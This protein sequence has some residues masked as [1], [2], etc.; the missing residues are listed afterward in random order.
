MVSLGD[1]ILGLAPDNWTSD[2]FGPGE[3]DVAQP[4]A[5]G[6]QVWKTHEDTGA[7]LRCLFRPLRVDDR[8]MI[9]W[10]GQHPVV[11]GRIGTDFG[12]ED[13]GDPM[14]GGEAGPPGPQGPVGPTGP[15]GATGPA[16]P[17]G[18]DG[19]QGPVGA[20]GPQGPIG[21]TGPVGPTG[22]QG[23]TGNTGPQGPQGTVGPIGPAGPQGDK[24]DTGAT[25]ATGP[26]GPK[27][28]T[29]AQGPI[30]LT[31]PQ[32][33]IGNTGP[34]GPV[35]PA[36]SIGSLPDGTVTAPG[37]AFAADTNTG[38]YRPANDTFGIAAGGQAALTLTPTQATFSGG[39]SG[40]SAVTNFQLT[41]PSSNLQLMAGGTNNVEL[42]TNGVRRWYVDGAT[43]GWFAGA[44][45]AY[46]IGA[47]GANR[48]RDLFVGR[49]QV[50]GGTT[51]HVGNVS[52]G[53]TPVTYSGLIFQP[54]LSGANQFAFYAPLTFSTSGTGNN[55]AVYVLPTF[56]AG[57]RTVTSGASFYADAPTLGAGVTVT[58]MFGLYVA[59]Q[60]KTGVTNAYGIYIAAQAG[61]TTTNFGIRNDGT[62]RLS[63]RVGINNDPWVDNTRYV[64]ISGVVSIFN[65]TMSL[66]NGMGVGPNAATM[67]NVGGNLTGAATQNGMY[68]RVNGDATATAQLC[69]IAFQIGTQNGSYTIPN[70]TGIYV[71][72]PIV[73]TGTTITNARGIN[74]VNQGGAGRVNAYGMYLQATSGASG[75][76]VSLYN[77]GT[78]QFMDRIGVMQGPN[79]AVLVSLR[80]QGTAGT[81][82]GFQYLKSDASNNL[83]YTRDDGMMF[84]TGPV[85]VGT[86]N[87]R[88][89]N[90]P[91]S[92]SNLSIESWDGYVM[93]SSLSG[94]HMGGNAYWDGT[95]WQRFS[96]AAAA[97]AWIINAGAASFYTVAAGANPISWTAPFS[98]SNTGGVTADAFA[99]NGKPLTSGQI[100]GNYFVSDGG[101]DL[102]NG[103]LY[104]AHN[105]GV[106]WSWNGTYL[107]STHSIAN[108]GTSYFFVNNSSVYVQ[109]TG[110]L[111]FSHPIEIARGSV[112]GGAVITA[113]AARG[114]NAPMTSAGQG[115]FILG[116]GNSTLYMH[117]NLSVAIR[118]DYPTCTF[119][120]YGSITVNGVVTPSSQRY[121]SDIVTIPHALQL[122]MD[123]NIEGVHYTY[124]PPELADFYTQPD[125]KYGF[126]AEPWYDKA[127]DVVTLDTGGEPHALDYQQITAILF[128]AF[129]EYVVQTDERIRQLE[130]GV[131]A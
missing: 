13:V 81:T 96:T 16:G 3:F 84:T 26:Q 74:V 71:D 114:Y 8:V 115:D 65:G 76:N 62:T 63:G 106:N 104:F 18:P 116:G 69:G 58:S 27:G 72:G 21:N 103:P 57:T 105:G 83:F 43:G 25:G 6:L 113:Q 54:T 24:G 107:V 47:S 97:A 41:A 67:L 85:W 60:G 56:A 90:P 82:Y 36:G 100:Y 68:F 4:F 14:G 89:R 55:F 39:I 38:L 44:D 130:E 119:V 46:D 77:L 118:Q 78:S 49:N 102:G 11:T 111:S 92:I 117:P 108:G 110:N 80:A 15:P 31:G 129:R 125:K 48:P 33:P 64:A 98:I 30:G 75:D 109:W 10:F 53:T 20:T 95:N 121:K 88:I 73:A 112:G 32:G 29:G 28:D 45:N 99:T 22:P 101:L 61:A 87:Q 5:D 37:L 127:P 86:P 51:Q 94:T 126:L 9:E 52:I 124:N 2:P 123:P 19:V 128:Q 93:V 42:F 122:V 50:V 59:N 70:G 34:Q 17:R 35:G 79:T 7:V 23:P 131:A 91:S 120:G 66:D 40:G 1:D 12:D